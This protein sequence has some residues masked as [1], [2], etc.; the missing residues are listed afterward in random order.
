[1]RELME[2]EDRHPDLRSPDSPTQRVGAAPLEKF[3]PFTHH[4]AMLSLA[5]AFSDEDLLDFAERLR[6]FPDVGDDISY[7]VEPKLDGVAV[8]LLYENGVLKTPATRGDGAIGEDVTQNVRTIPTVP[9]AL[10]PAPG[11]KATAP[12]RPPRS[13]RLWRSVVKSLLKPRH[14]N[15]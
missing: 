11:R 4:S 3:A 7:V 8:N 6:R 5:N 15:D 13:H 1:M 14:S 10:F 9:L 2:L 12:P